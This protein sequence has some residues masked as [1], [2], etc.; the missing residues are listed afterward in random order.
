MF[1][2]ASISRC[3]YEQHCIRGCNLSAFS[4]PDA[5][6]DQRPRRMTIRARI[7]SHDLS[8]TRTSKLSKRNRNATTADA[9]RRASLAELNPVTQEILKANTMDRERD[10]DGDMSETAFDLKL[11]RRRLNKTSIPSKRGGR[12]RGYRVLQFTCCILNRSLVY[13]LWLI[14]LSYRPLAVER[15]PCNN[16]N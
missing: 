10:G 4:V 8:E 11:R 5:P 14:A 2:K 7:E 12:A 13:K 3:H 16:N 1:I 15:R 9:E 6:C